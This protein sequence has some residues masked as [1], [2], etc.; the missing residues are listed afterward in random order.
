MYIGSAFVTKKDVVTLRRAI[1]ALLPNAARMKVVEIVADWEKG[2]WI[3]MRELF[4]QLQDD[5]FQQCDY[6]YSSNIQK[7]AKSKGKL[8]N[9]P[10][11]S[12]TIAL[13][14]P[15]LTPLYECRQS[16]LILRCIEKLGYVQVAHQQRSLKILSRKMA[17]LFDL[18]LLPGD[19][20]QGWNNFVRT[21][22][23]VY[24]GPRATYG[25]PKVRHILIVWDGAFKLIADFSVSTTS[26]TD[27]Q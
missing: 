4:P 15:G 9:R 10:E 22:E 11:S 13:N 26:N 21:V 16:R 19:L 23:A 5:A 8:F 20:R 3:I 2:P 18:D 27:G 17:T 12:E 6:H 1:S 14:L 24:I 7:T 25:A